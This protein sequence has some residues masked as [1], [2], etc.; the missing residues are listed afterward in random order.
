M[1][2]P[3]SDKENPPFGAPSRPLGEEVLQSAED[4][5][6]TNPAS[7]DGMPDHGLAS[8]PQAADTAEA[9]A[10]KVS[11]L[12]RQVAE[13]PVFSALLAFAAGALLIALV[14]SA[15]QRGRR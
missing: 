12:A 14:R 7:V 4:A 10:P 1:T 3:A 13:Q 11:K 8:D 15:L 9:R 6:L 5:V 2:M